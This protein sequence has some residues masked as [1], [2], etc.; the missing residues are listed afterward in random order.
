MLELALLAASTS[1]KVVI[2]AGI[3]APPVVVVVAVLTLARLWRS[4][5]RRILAVASVFAALLLAVELVFAFTMGGE[6]ASLTVR[7]ETQWQ[8]EVAGPDIDHD[9]VQP[10]ES[11]TYTNHGDHGFTGIIDDVEILGGPTASTH[12]IIHGLEAGQSFEI[13]VTEAMIAGPEPAQ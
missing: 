10:G 5:E 11:K 1:E 2:I 9:A 7:N 12:V 3:L 8:V 4:Q 6:D 13:I